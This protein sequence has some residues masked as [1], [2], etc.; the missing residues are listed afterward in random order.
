MPLVPERVGVSGRVLLQLP[1]RSPGGGAVGLQPRVL[2]HRVLVAGRAVHA[3]GAPPQDAT[4]EE[5]PRRG[6]KA[7]YCNKT[8]R[9]YLFSVTCE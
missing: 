2:Q 3:A 6:I 7:N 9:C 5:A 8:Q 1:V 4:E